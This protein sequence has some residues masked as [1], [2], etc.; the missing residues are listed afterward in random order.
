MMRI[1]IV[2]AGLSGLTLATELKTHAEVHVFEKSR[3]VGGRMA[4]RRAGIFEFDHGTQFF[5]ARTQAF[6]DYLET[7]IEQGV[8]AEWTG[9][10]IA[11]R[12]DSMPEDRPWL[13]PH[14]VAVPQMN[15][16]CKMLAE[17][18]NVS[19]NT[20]VAPLVERTAN[21][22]QLTDT[23]SRDLGIFDWVISTAPPVQTRAIFHA[24]LR[25]EAQLAHAELQGCY[26]LMLGF[27][28]K[29]DRPWTAA[30]IRE[31]PIEWIAVNAT[32]PQRNAELTTLVAHSSNAW[33]QAHIDDSQPEVQ[34]FLQAQLMDV[35]GID[36]R[37]ADFTALHRWRYAL[38]AEPAQRSPYVDEVRQ[39][40]CTG[41]W[42]SASRIEVVWQSAHSLADRFQRMSGFPSA[43]QTDD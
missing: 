9:K 11:M 12:G 24:Y 7:L 3:G 32:K 41:D 8:V 36:P 40:A 26:T 38:L 2:G 17:S 6:R 35:T 21:G 10:V 29:W 13:E 31:N 18:C 33:A 4:T 27:S 14:Y 19:L 15:S 16:L 37:D 22:W 43:V 1:A 39:I 20:Q 42:C 5:T 23:E 30:K 34:N 28:R 25:P